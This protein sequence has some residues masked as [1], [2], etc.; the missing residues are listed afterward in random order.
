MNS[1][2][3]QGV[4]IVLDKMEKALV[5]ENVLV[6]KKVDLAFLVTLL[7]K[8]IA[9]TAKLKTNRTYILLPT[10]ESRNLI[11]FLMRMQS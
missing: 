3:L 5:Q 6:K 1:N 4:V 8:E 11:N 10:R 2:K 7:R 9:F